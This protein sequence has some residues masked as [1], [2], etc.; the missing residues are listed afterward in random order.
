MVNNLL[1]IDVLCFLISFNNNANTN[2][3]LHNYI[4]RTINKLR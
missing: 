1:L 2:L 4:I 3:I